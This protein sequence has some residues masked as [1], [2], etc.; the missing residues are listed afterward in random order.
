MYKIKLVARTPFFAEWAQEQPGGRN[1]GSRLVSWQL[2]TSVGHFCVQLS[3]F[4]F[5]GFVTA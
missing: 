3:I 2:Q 4:G 1:V 5:C